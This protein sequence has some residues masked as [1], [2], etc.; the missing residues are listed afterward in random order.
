M[1]T[2]NAKNQEPASEG[3]GKNSPQINRQATASA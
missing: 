1:A 3:I 2:A